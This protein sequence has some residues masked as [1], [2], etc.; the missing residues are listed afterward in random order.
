MTKTRV[1]FNFD[2]QLSATVESSD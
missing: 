2:D 1:A